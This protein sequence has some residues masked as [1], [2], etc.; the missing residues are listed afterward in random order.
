M[1]L[2]VMEKVCHRVNQEQGLD[3]QIQ[4]VFECW[5]EVFYKKRDAVVLEY[6]QHWFHLP[7][8][9][10]FA[11]NTHRLCVY[12]PI[13]A[14][15]NASANV[16]GSNYTA[17]QDEITKAFNLIRCKKVG[18]L[19]K[20][21]Q[22]EF[23]VN[24]IHSN[25]HFFKVLFKEQSIPQEPYHRNYLRIDLVNE[26]PDFVGF[27]ESRIKNL[28]ERIEN[29]YI[30]IQNKS[31]QSKLPQGYDSTGGSTDTFET[32]SRGLNPE[33]TPLSPLPDFFISPVLIKKCCGGLR[34]Y[35]SMPFNC[36]VTEWHSSNIMRIIA[37][38]QQDSLFWQNKHF[39]GK[40][41]IKYNIVEV[42][43]N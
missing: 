39:E 16:V 29:G 8:E 1:T 2:Y 6:A 13:E 11:S 34:Y 31:Y 23:N 37:K 24:N 19:Y 15:R 17:I 5:F 10:I 33:I 27:F 14:T 41:N 9:E 20:H 12:T 35:I 32:C 3:A 22:S 30:Q 43:E 28:R 42:I 38:F 40:T 21:F 26:H 4:L 18:S 25:S 36:M 7:Q